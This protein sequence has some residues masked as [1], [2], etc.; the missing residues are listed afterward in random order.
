MGFYG[1]YENQFLVAQS[2][3]T[4]ISLSFSLATVTVRFLLCV[5]L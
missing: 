2:E 3:L 5:L 1:Y 4:N